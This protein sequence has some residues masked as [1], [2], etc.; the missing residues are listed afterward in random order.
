MVYE[1]E[2]FEMLDK[3][4]FVFV[5]DELNKLVK[6]KNQRPKLVNVKTGKPVSMH[7]RRFYVE[8]LNDIHGDN[9][10]VVNR[11][12]HPFNL[13]YKADVTQCIPGY[14]NIKSKT[15]KDCVL[16]TEKHGGYLQFFHPDTE[17]VLRIALNSN[18]YTP[19][20]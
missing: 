6:E 9:F 10:E 19:K 18:T 4:L 8:S 11:T 14:L 5:E 12:T 7:P 13:P 3:T 16:M 15:Y 1:V 20:Q 17:K 2:R